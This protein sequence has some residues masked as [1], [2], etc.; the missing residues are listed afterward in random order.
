MTYPRK[1]LALKSTIKIDENRD[2]I[3]SVETVSDG[4]REWFSGILNL[5]LVGAG[6]LH[7]PLKPAI[8]MGTKEQI[9]C[10]QV[11]SGQ[12]GRQL[13]RLKPDAS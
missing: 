11:V 4:S 7:L 6:L 13:L 1:G 2:F 10:H 8:R 12:S 5:P 3:F 9:S